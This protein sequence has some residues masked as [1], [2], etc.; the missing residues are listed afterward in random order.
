MY[1]FNRV[2]DDR[3]VLP[4][5]TQFARM[6]Q[7]ITSI[8]ALITVHWMLKAKHVVLFTYLEMKSPFKMTISMYYMIYQNDT[9]TDTRYQS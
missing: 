4:L 7:S 5:R 1:V 6:L 2:A 3:S 8:I 9:Y